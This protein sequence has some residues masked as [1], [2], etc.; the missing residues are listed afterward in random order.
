[1]SIPDLEL[2]QPGPGETFSLAEGFIF[3]CTEGRPLTLPPRLRI[4]HT[5]GSTRRFFCIVDNAGVVWTNASRPGDREQM[6]RRV[7]WRESLNLLKMHVAD[8]MFDRII[9]VAS[10]VQ[11]HLIEMMRKY[12]EFAGDAVVQRYLSS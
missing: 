7:T 1:M 8:P 2:L 12:A 3:V 5:D 9:E 4:E 11:P 6:M 10:S